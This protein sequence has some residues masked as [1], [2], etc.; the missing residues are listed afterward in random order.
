MIILFGYLK[1]CK[2]DLF[3]VLYVM[4]SINCDLVFLLNEMVFV[5]FWFSLYRRGI[6]VF[7]GLYFEG[8]SLCVISI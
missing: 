1:V 3:D 6:F 2:S 5:F 8:Y 7:D 4:F